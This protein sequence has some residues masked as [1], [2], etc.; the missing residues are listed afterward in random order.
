MQLAEDSST[1]Q[2]QEKIDKLL[3]VMGFDWALVTDLSTISDFLTEEE[4]VQTLSRKLG[5]EVKKKD[6]IFEVAMR[7]AKAN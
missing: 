6:Y 2:H 3:E 7:M 1:R 5:F 4:D